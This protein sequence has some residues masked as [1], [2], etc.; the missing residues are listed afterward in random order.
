[1][2]K[3]CLIALLAL[4]PLFAHGAEPYREYDL[5]ETYEPHVSGDMR[6][7]AATA[8]GR[9]PGTWTGAWPAIRMKTG[10]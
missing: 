2:R 6:C 8:T 10:S 9:T 5:A 3:T 7:P 4:A 1:M